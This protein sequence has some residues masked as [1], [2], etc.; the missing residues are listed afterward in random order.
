MVNPIVTVNI[1]L[2]S[3]PVPS[4]LQKTGAIISQGGTVLGERNYSLITS[5]ADLTPLLNPAL[6]LTS[7]SWSNVYGGR[8]T[9]TPAV[10]HGIPV[11]MQFVTTISGVV[12]SGYNGTYTCIA[13]S[14][15]AFV[16]YLTNNPGA[17]VTAGTYTPYGVGDLVAAFTSYFAQGSQQSVYVL[18]LGNTSVSAA[19]ANL[20]SF[21]AAQPSQKFYA[22]L[23]PRNWDATSD[24]LALI[25]QYENTNSQT[26]FFTTTTLQNYGAYDSTMKDVIALVEAPAYGIWPANVITAGSYSGGLVTLTTTTNHGV[27]PGQYFTIAGVSP[28]AFNGTYYAS[29]GT[30]GT[31]L[32]YAKASSPGSYVSGGTLVQSFYSSPGIPATEFTL[33]TYFQVVLSQAP[34]AAIKVPPFAFTFLYGVTAYPLPGNASILTTLANANVSYV[35]DSGQGGLTPNMLFKGH[36]MDGQAFNYWYSID[37]FAINLT[38]NL[39]NAVI[40]GSNNKPNPLYYN[41]NGINRLEQVAFNTAYTAVSYGL[42]LGTAKQYQYAPDVFNAKYNEG[43]FAGQLAINAVPFTDYTTLNPNDYDTRTYGGLSAIAIPLN[44]F[45]HIV[46]NLVATQFV[47]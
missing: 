36:T 45:E 25:N 21:I 3:P 4:N 20:T 34:T 7:V 24:F 43:D 42:F 9:A 40:N 38:L 23:V 47:G 2:Q 28:S 14:S 22:Y 33:A 11:G 6:S 44:G 32:V 31:S 1:S 39:A 19:I 27:S 13:T 10:A 18:E 15:S 29:Y 12:P 8:V 5:M 46:F 37:W 41:Q 26:Y 17:Q 35:A 16:Y 30:T